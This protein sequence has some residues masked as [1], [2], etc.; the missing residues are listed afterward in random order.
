MLIR[1]A[2][3]GHLFFFYTVTT[4]SIICLMLSDSSQM[5]LRLI[6]LKCGAKGLHYFVLFH[7]FVCERIGMNM[8]CNESVII[9]FCR[10]PL[11]SSLR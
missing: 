1:V 9:F 2:V 5:T 7:A 11:C 10:S 3:L 8:K 4:F 6:A